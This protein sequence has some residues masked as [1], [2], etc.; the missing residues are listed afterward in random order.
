MI[1]IGFGYKK[2]TG[3]DTAVR[4]AL[5]F[6]R[7]YFPSIATG[8]ISFGNQLKRVATVMFEWAGLK[9]GDY[10]NNYP[11][12]IEVPLTTCGLS[13]RQIWDKIGLMGREIYPKVWVE[14]A[15]MDV[16]ADA[17]VLFSKDVRFPTEID[18]IDRFHGYKYRI[19]RNEAPQGGAVDQALND[20]TGWTGI[21][22]N[23]GLGTLKD[24]N[25]KIKQIVCRH[26]NPLVE[27]SRIVCP[28]CFATHK[29]IV[30][31][32]ENGIKQV[33]CGHCG[34]DYDVSID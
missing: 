34:K 22:Q 14:M 21:I 28:H 29:S 1:I 13:P 9:P 19:D 3:K 26:L 5:S 10:Y 11:E 7:Q 23:H 20:Y 15:A 32:N 4:F 6:A 8:E 33:H 17:E 24:F 12:Q 16:D 2:R 25:V 30:F 18:I 27:E 31:R